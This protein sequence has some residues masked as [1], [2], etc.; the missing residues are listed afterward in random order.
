MNAKMRA[1][2]EAECG[3][4]Y[5]GWQVIIN[6]DGF[7]AALHETGRLKQECA[8]GMSEGTANYAENYRLTL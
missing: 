6:R 3:V 1:E 2:A 8:I 7:L 5:I 4:S